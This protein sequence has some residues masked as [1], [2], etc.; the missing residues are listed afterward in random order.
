MLH[1]P[2][3]KSCQDGMR[4]SHMSV[5]ASLGIAAGFDMMLAAAS[6][7]FM[8]RRFSTDFVRWGMV[9]LQPGR[10]KVRQL[11]ADQVGASKHLP[12]CAQGSAA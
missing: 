1:S 10:D 3:V 8:A 4:R 5:E 11:R 7:A 9:K 2:V 6:I 12:T